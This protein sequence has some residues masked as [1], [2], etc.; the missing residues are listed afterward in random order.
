MNENDP[1]SQLNNC[2]T[3]PIA[4]RKLSPHEIGI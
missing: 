1:L 4:E 2:L 3:K